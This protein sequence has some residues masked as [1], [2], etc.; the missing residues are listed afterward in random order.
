MSE[1]SMPDTACLQ[2]AIADTVDRYPLST[3]IGV[4][5]A[6]VGLGAL[7]ATHLMPYEPPTTEQSALAIG[8]Q[9]LHSMSEYLPRSMRG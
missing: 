4:F 9:V 8:R 6:G 3:V 2:N 1:N 5:G 7:L